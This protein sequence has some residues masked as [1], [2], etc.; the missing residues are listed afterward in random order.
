MGTHTVGHEN[1]PPALRV[2]HRAEVDRY[3][4]AFLPDRTR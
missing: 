1:A 2:T 3:L 4:F